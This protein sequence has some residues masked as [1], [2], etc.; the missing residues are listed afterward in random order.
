MADIPSN[1]FH[2]PKEELRGVL[3]QGYIGSLVSGQGFSRSVMYLTDKR[4]YQRGKIFQRNAKGKW[5]STK[6][7]RA[8]GV[9][10]ITGTAFQETTVFWKLV[11]GL[12]ACLCVLDGIAA[13]VQKG[14]DDVAAWAVTIVFG[15]LGAFFL[16]SYYLNRRRL[17]IVQYAGGEIGTNCRWYSQEEIEAL[18]SAISREKDRVSQGG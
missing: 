5:R 15:S 13:L 1:F 16:L 3:G 7:V 17:F 14:G 10:D 12:S 9:A 18:Q 2:D 8:V 6:G 11:L 4:L